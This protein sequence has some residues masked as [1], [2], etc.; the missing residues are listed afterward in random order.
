[1]RPVG[2][3]FLWKLE[4]HLFPGILLSLMIMNGFVCFMGLLL[5]QCGNCELVQL[6]LM[7]RIKKKKKDSNN[8]SLT[9]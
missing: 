3:V 5:L 2:K 8:W 4:G 1:M 7:C 9:L 6:G